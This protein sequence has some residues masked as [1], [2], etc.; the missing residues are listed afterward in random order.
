MKHI[1]FIAALCIFS[2]PVRA[3]S[4]PHE[5]IVIKVNGMICDFCAQSVW[6]I[7]EDY[8]GVNNIDI[9]LDTGNVTVHMKPGKTLL[10]EQLTK[11]ITYAGYDLVNIDRISD[12]HH[13]ESSN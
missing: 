2:L 4:T 12:A 6:K 11:G 3:D 8:E 10:D 7:F 9:N 13:A 1:L 5:D